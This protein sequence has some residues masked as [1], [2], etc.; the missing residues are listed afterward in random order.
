MPFVAFFISLITFAT[1]LPSLQNGFV[2][3][4]DDA[5]VYENQNIRSINFIFLKWIFTA[6]ANP[7][8]HPLTLLSLAVDYQKWG[9]NP[10]GYHLANIVFHSVNTFLVFLLTFN[11][12]K[13]IGNQKN[14]IVA[15]IT[16]L[17]FGIHPLHV[18]SVAWVSERKDVLYAFFFLLAIL[19]YLRYLSDSRKKN[20]YYILSII[21]FTLALMSKPMAMT[22]PIVLLILDF[23]PLKRLSIWGLIE[24]IPFFILSAISTA[25]T[26]YVHHT[27]NLL[28]SLE[29][30]P[31]IYR[32]SIATHA[33]MFYLIK[34]V[35]PF[36]L[37][38]FYPYPEMQAIAL[39]YVG[40]G[41]L[42]AVITILCIRAAK[43][44]K[45]FLAVWL[46]YIITLL[47][48]SGIV[49]VGVHAMAD[50]YTYL[51]ALGPF[52]L[53]GVGF[54]IV[55]ERF[56][57]KK[58]Y[59]VLGIAALTLLLGLLATKTVKQISIWHDPITLWAH[60]IKHYPKTVI[61]HYNLGNAYSNLGNYDQAIIEYTKAIRL[62]PRTPDI[63]YNLGNA[64]SNLGNYDQAI[65]EYT[66]AI[67]LNPRY[68]DA[69]NNRGLAYLR[70]GNYRLAI[71][72]SLKAIELN[73]RDEV[74]YNNRGCAYMESRDYK[75]AI[76]DFEKAIEL[77]PM[78]ATAYYNLGSTYLWM[79]NHEQALISYKKAASLGIKEPQD[80]LSKVNPRDHVIS[81]K[82]L[83]EPAD[84]NKA[85]RRG[86]Y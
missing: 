16:A 32:L 29:Q 21:L 69:Y 4:D 64:Y 84:Y 55:V 74:A 50:R 10:F 9:L 47:P 66:K 18:E 48:V 68:L 57:K 12:A 24:K 20:T 6:E 76:T 19:A 79:G 85:P 22:L 63:Y 42:L 52:M 70:S 43:R 73:P 51:P 31:L 8:W 67:G 37:A 46:S 60:E 3:W 17:L 78:Y 77:N 81:P 49:K 53:I 54:S 34:M 26:I 44:N 35:F 39:L 80:A 1:Y 65:I 36:N 61:S 56:S 25:I 72:D 75:S 11:L 33:Y 15:A 30:Y 27:R 2:N 41:I 38:P 40:Y 13:T 86:T 71:I 14:L 83:E 5:Y 28:V 23:Y 62:N 45:V 7:T 58:I 59:K 82:R